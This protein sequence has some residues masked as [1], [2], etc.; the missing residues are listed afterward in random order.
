MLVGL[1]AR[2]SRVNRTAQP[3]NRVTGMCTEQADTWTATIE[4]VTAE[5]V[6]LQNNQISLIEYGH[7]IQY[8]SQF[9]KTTWIFHSLYDVESPN[10]V[11]P[12]QKKVGSDPDTSENF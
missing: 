5:F 3:Y 11:K 1:M 9:S 7:T 4:K 6:A 2:F 8:K 12:I 10:H